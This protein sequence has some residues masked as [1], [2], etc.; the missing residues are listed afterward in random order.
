MI[1]HTHNW[2]KTGIWETKTQAIYPCLYPDC[3]TAL[4]KIPGEDVSTGTILDNRIADVVKEFEGLIFDD[5]SASSIVKV[6]MTEV[7]ESYKFNRLKLK[8]NDVVIDIGAHIGIICLYL[9][10]R[11][12]AITIYAFEP[13][14]ENFEM[15]NHNIEANGITNV[16]AINRAVTGD[17]RRLELRVDFGTNS[18]GGSAYVSEKAQG[19]TVE[20]ESVTLS[21]IFNDYRLDRCRLLK[22]DSEGAEYEILFN[23]PPNI[24]S[25]VDIIQGEF[26][27]NKRLRRDGYKPAALR[28]WLRQLV[29]RVR[30]GTCKMAE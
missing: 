23:T 19:K 5:Q 24:L 21:Q 10:K 26:H 3:P 14:P 18:G 27:T 20:A 7:I 13:V 6:I 29:K 1:L 17:G 28:K 2:S 25:R 15:L 8:P 16:I 30:V 4:L 9:A 11:Y 12:P 22:I